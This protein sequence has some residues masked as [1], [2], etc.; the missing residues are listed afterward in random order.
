MIISEFHTTNKKQIKN[1]R[2]KYFTKIKYVWIFVLLLTAINVTLFLFGFFYQ[3]NSDLKSHRINTHHKKECLLKSSL[4]LDK[5]QEIQYDSIKFQHQ[6]IAK[7]IVDSL[8]ISRNTLMI[9]LKKDNVSEIEIDSI[10]QIINIFNNKLFEQSISQYLQIKQILLP[11]QKDTLSSIYCEI[12]G[13]NNMENKHNK[14]HSK[15][16]NCFKCKK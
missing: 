4:N 1:A 14:C 13:C 9:M 11:A 10:V 8:R 6:I 12:F 5:N 16:S 2:M 7:Q 15:D 3:R